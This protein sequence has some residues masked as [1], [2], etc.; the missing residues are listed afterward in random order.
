MSEMT[1]K[2]PTPY[3]HLHIR[4]VSDRERNQLHESIQQHYRITGDIRLYHPAMTYMKPSWSDYLRTDSYT[5]HT[6][7]TVVQLLKRRSSMLPIANVFRA[8]VKTNKGTYYHTDVFVKELP[9]FRKCDIPLFLRRHT[10]TPFSREDHFQSQ[11]LHSMDSP[12][13]IE[14]FVNLCLSKLVELELCPHFCRLYGTVGA[15]LKRCS[16]DVE[17]EYKRQNTQFMETLLQSAKEGSET[18]RFFPPVASSEKHRPPILECQNMPVYLMISEKSD[19]DIMF[20]KENGVLDDTIFTSIVFQVFAGLYMAQRYYGLQHNDLHLY[21]IMLSFTGES[22]LYYRYHDT[23]YKIPTYGYV[24]KLIDWGRSNYSFQ[25]FQSN[26]LHFNMEGDC[27]EQFVRPYLNGGGI[28]GQQLHCPVSLPNHSD[29]RI[30]AASLLKN[31]PEYSSTET[32]K[33][34]KSILRIQDGGCLTTK[35]F[36]WKTYVEASKRTFS[37]SPTM[38]F[39]QSFLESFYVSTETPSKVYVIQ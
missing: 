13:N 28:R 11:I 18:F 32:G 33:F 14:V 17:Y 12:S 31:L 35:R 2:T 23:I 27:F 24:V 26:N 19:V 7:H 4:R 29:Y 22:H 9:L 20:L 5:F 36:G 25:G 34:L 30:F 21:N 1:Q 38:F 39:T 37:V 8:R 6:S 16:F 10:I 15:T 3:T